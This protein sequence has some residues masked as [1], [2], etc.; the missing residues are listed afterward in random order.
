M[1]RHI[2]TE[3]S[4]LW[5]VLHEPFHIG[6]TLDIHITLRLLL[7]M[8]HVLLHICPEIPKVKIHILREERIL[9]RGEDN[10]AEF[11]TDVRHCSE[12]DTPILNSQ[13]IMHHSLIRPL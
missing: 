13:K 5:V 6:D 1:F 9:I 11:R 4:E 3:S 10:L 12:R 2:A 8:V 7:K